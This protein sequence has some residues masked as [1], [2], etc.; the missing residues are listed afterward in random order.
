MLAQ[1]FTPAPMHYASRVLSL[2]IYVST[3]MT[4]SWASG[5]FSMAIASS[6]RHKSLFSSHGSPRL[7]PKCCHKLSPRA[8]GPSNVTSYDRIIPEGWER[9]ELQVEYVSQCRPRDLAMSP[10]N[11]VHQ[12]Y[13][14]VL[15]SSMPNSMRRRCRPLVGRCCATSPHYV[16]E[17]PPQSADLRKRNPRLNRRPHSR[18][19]PAC[20]CFAFK[21]T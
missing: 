20:P 8:A 4:R 10:S 21:K 2:T 19:L 16:V 7:A 9:R 5:G 13:P 14:P 11:I 18:T 6:R 3:S 1:S 12:L 17:E 15:A